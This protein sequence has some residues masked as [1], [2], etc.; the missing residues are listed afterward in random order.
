MKERH[1]TAI[2]YTTACKH[3][4]EKQPTVL[5]CSKQDLIMLCQLYASLCG[6]LDSIALLLSNCLTPSDDVHE[7][8][9]HVDLSPSSCPGPTWDKV[10]SDTNEELNSS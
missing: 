4:R 1:K 5:K 8:T 3:L 6:L 10:I 2:T 7:D 9:Q